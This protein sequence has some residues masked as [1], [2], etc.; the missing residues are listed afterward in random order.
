M[1]V[2]TFVETTPV[3]GPIMMWSGLVSDIPSG[4]LLCDGNNGTP[5]LTDSFY[6][7]MGTD[8]ESPYSG[9]GND[10]YTMSN[11][12]MPSHN[13]D[14]NTSTDGDHNHDIGVKDSFNGSGVY[15]NGASRYFTDTVYNK[16]TTPDQGNHSHSTSDDGAG[17]GSS[18][19]NRPSYYEIAYIT[20]S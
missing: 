17:S 4:W 3:D 6:K 1:T 2:S 20:I 9:G 15:N 18:I 8:F 13:H 16:I 14:T 5:D 10:S 7:G 12:Q 19:D 11:S